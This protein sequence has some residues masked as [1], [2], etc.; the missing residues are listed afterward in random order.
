MN[1][2]VE[3]TRR[4]SD[5]YPVAIAILD[6]SAKAAIP[7]GFISLAS[8]PGVNVAFPPALFLPHSTTES[9]RGRTL[10]RFRNSVPDR[11]GAAVMVDAA[12]ISKGYAIIYS[13]D[14]G[15]QAEV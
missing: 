6:C 2:S 3:E 7:F 5:V 10:G 13:A 11:N 8:E 15:G 12:V 1:K 9:Q 4:C 14:R